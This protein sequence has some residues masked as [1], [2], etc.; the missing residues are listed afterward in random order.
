VTAALDRLSVPLRPEQG[1]LYGVP[2]LAGEPYAAERE[3]TLAALAAAHPQNAF[4]QF[5]LAWE[6]RLGGHVRDAELAYRHV[7]ER[8]PHNDRAMNNLGNT[9]A[10]Q[11]RSDE[12]L[13]FYQKAYAENPMNAA[14][15]F[16]ASQIFTQRFE[17]RPAT[18]ALSR[19]SALDFDLV[20]N[21]QS[22]ST[23]DGL[24]PLVDQWLDPRTFWEALPAFPA[25]AAGQGVLPPG[26]R[27]RVECS[28]WPFSIF[29][30]LLAL[31]SVAMG[32]MQHRNMP[33]RSCSNC[34]RVIC[35]RCA[36][37]RRE[38]ALCPGCAAVETRA[39]TPDFARVLLQ[40]H[41]RTIQHS[42][43][44]IRTALATLI[45]GYGLL[46][47]QRAALPFVLL[48][49][50]AALTAPWIGLSAP[51]SFEP[52]LA[53]SSAEVPLPLLMGIWISVYALS[54]IGYFS[55]LARIRSQ[56]ASLSGP[57]R[58]RSAQ[59]SRRV[60]AAAA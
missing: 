36:E 26:W 13:V 47:L 43:D 33:L 39:E 56:A 48:V 54:L 60:T 40:Q 44:M 27:T 41:R 46:S 4:V 18:D 8:W 29:A 30:V 37:R 23:E 24:L 5:G 19:A 53:L 50:T 11:G 25:A 20:K 42:Q 32:V 9:L 52:R 58:S 22:Q 6:A 1:P 31:L 59:A 2:T 16:N 28:G 49:V 7:L 12:A 45:P 3:R 17:Y 15:Y 35:R 34:G 14:A 55:Q 21:Y 51:F 57:I 10:M 38:T